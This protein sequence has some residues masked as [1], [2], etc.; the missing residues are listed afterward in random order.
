[1]FLGTTGVC[2]NFI[3]DYAKSAGPLNELFRN[4]TPFV[5]GPEQEKAMAE[6]KQALGNAVPL[7]NIDYDSEGTVVLA[8]D[9][10]YKAVGFYIY[11]E[12]ADRKRKLNLGLL[13]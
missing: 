9:T 12:S 4:N 6:L 1:M 13:L 5:W 11:Q 10:S 3:K 2:R 7:G 8:V